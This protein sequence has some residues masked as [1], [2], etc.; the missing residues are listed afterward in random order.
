M[1]YILDPHKNTYTFLYTKCLYIFV[2]THTHALLLN[3]SCIPVKAHK[4]ITDDAL[5]R[6]LERVS[7]LFRH[8]AERRGYGDSACILYPFTPCNC[9]QSDIE[10]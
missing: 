6:T 3:M 8:L 4:S 1:E 9:L 10:S 2:H 7:P 5:S